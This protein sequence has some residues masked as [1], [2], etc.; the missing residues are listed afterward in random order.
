LLAE[1]INMNRAELL[2]LRGVASLQDAPAERA[3]SKKRFESPAT[4]A[5][6]PSNCA[7]R[8]ASPK[9]GKAKANSPK[10]GNCSA[11][12]TAGSPKASTPPI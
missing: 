1:P 4:N 3:I 5:P 7:Q 10:R 6:S 9:S 8:P 2:R 12:S 11:A